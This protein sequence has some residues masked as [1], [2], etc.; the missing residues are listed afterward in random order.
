MEMKLK[1][2]FVAICTVLSM[3][4]LFASVACGKEDGGGTSVGGTKSIEESCSKYIIS[5]I[6]DGGFYNPSAAR[7]LSASYEDGESNIYVMSY[8]CTAILFLT[9]QGTNKLGGTLN[10]KYAI[11]IG[12]SEDGEMFSAESVSAT[13]DSLNVGTI[14]QLIKKHWIDLGII[15]G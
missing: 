12:G 9:I 14:N 13:G 7:V 10:K 1:K 15:D 4:M 3:V 5:A 6:E 8:D 11:V 2:F